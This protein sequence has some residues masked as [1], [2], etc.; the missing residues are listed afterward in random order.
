MMGCDG[1]ELWNP[2]AGIKHCYA[3]TLH[4]IRKNHPGFAHPF[5][6][7]TLFLDRLAQGLK[8]KN[9]TD[10]DRPDRPW[11]NGFPRLIFCND[12]GDTFTESLSIDWLRECIEPMEASSHQ[13]L[14]LT[15]RPHRMRQFFKEFGHV[16]ANFWLGTSVSSRENVQRLG[17][18]QQIDHS[19][20]R[21]LSYE[22]AIGPLGPVDL[23]GISWVIF[24][25]ESGPRFRPMAP[26]W[27]REIRDQCVCAKVAFFYK[28]SAARKDETHPWVV[29]EDGSRWE[30]RQ[31]PGRLTPPTRVAHGMPTSKGVRKATSVSRRRT[32][33]GNT[34]PGTFPIIR[35]RA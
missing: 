11:L 12:M 14:I 13:W 10:T 2:T 34:H 8:W 7:P 32:Q 21:F 27:A 33:I 26:A 20:I 31:M 3:G 16:P 6:S 15:K 4:R 9:L 1:C 17:E 35:H 5:E 23:S 25:G 18:L 24:G 30:Y 19:G 28:Q 22:P 29:E